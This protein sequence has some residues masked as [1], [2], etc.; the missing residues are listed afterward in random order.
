MG[1]GDGSRGWAFWRA[2]IG[3]WLGAPNFRAVR[4]AL[5]AAVVLFVIGV[6]AVVADQLGGAPTRTRLPGSSGFPRGLAAASRS[7]PR[8][9]LTD[10]PAGAAKTEGPDESSTSGPGR[11][12]HYGSRSGAGLP[13]CARHWPRSFR[14]ARSRRC[15]SR[16]GH[17]PSLGGEPPNS[18][19]SSGLAS[20][21][22][23]VLR[24]YP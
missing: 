19:A 24:T 17:G 22:Y 10:S 20:W 18:R 14:Q 15:G 13:S 21:V 11:R 23:L 9:T 5:L 8:G 7:L 1:T 3:R 2:R 4:G 6:C 16:T 12:A